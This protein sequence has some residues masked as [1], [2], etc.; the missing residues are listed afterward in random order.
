MYKN[1]NKRPQLNLMRFLILFIFN[2][3]V[4]MWRKFANSASKLIMLRNNRNSRLQENLFIQKQS[5]TR[6]LERC[7]SRFLWKHGSYS[8]TT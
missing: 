6:K 2:K 8:R 4:D 7:E 1:I 5:P 3:L